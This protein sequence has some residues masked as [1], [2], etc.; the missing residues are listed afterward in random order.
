M[1]S[2]TESNCLVLVLAFLFLLPHLLSGFILFF[3]TYHSR[4]EIISLRSECDKFSL[5]ANFARE[6]LESFMKEFEHQVNI[7]PEICFMFSSS[8]VLDKVLHNVLGSFC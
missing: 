1:Y 8:L 5:E 7:L 2:L 4:S 3:L 6:K